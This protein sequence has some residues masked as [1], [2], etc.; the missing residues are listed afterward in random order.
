MSI[1]SYDGLQS[2]IATLLPD[3]SI[4][5]ISPADLR[6]ALTH[7]NDSHRERGVGIR[8]NAVGPINIPAGMSNATQ[9]GQSGQ[10]LGIFVEDVDFDP[11]DIVVAQSVTDDIG[12][13]AS[14]VFELSLRF[15]GEW[16]SND[17]LYLELRLNGNSF[18]PS[19]IFAGD[20]GNG[21]TDP[22]PLVIPRSSVIIP[23]ADIPGTISVWAW[24]DA[25]FTVDQLTIGVGV[26]YVPLT[27]GT[28]G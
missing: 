16:S 27:I 20:E 11:D 9:L 14:G 10:A 23:A 7:I 5:A 21:G 6:A 2:E 17:E 28:V 18:V 3:N 8:G 13:N 24:G 1:L 22:H 4:G 12:I 26:R 15:N 25:A 19:P